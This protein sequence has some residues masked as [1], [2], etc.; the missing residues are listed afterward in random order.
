VENKDIQEF[1]KQ[2]FEYFSSNCAEL[3][4]R[5]NAGAKLEDADKEAL[6]GHIQNFKTN[7]FKA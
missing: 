6:I 2:F 7:I 1:K 4:E 5:L 3:E